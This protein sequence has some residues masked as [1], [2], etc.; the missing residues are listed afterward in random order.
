MSDHNTNEDRDFCGENFQVGKMASQNKC[1][2]AQ[3]TS[4]QHQIH[5]NF[6]A[7]PAF[8]PTVK[9]TPETAKKTAHVFATPVTKA[10]NVAMKQATINQGNKYSSHSSFEVGA[11]ERDS[12]S[13]VIDFLRSTDMGYEF[14]GNKQALKTNSNIEVDLLRENLTRRGYT[15]EQINAAILILQRKANDSGKTLYERNKDVYFLLRYGVGV[16][17]SQGVHEVKV[18]L[19]DWE[20]IEANHFAFAEEVSIAG[21]SPSSKNKRPDIVIYINGIAVSVLELKRSSVTV[22]EGIRQ[23]LDNQKPMFIESFFSTVQFVMAGNQTEGIRYGTIG[24]KAKYYME[25]QE[26]PRNA[27]EASNKLLMHLSQLCNKERLFE[28]I[29]DF[30]LFDSGLKKLCRQ[31]QYFAVKAAQ[32]HIKDQIKGYDQHGQIIW[33]DPSRP[34]G[35]IWHTQGAG[36][37]LIMVLLWRWIAEFDPKAKLLIITDRKELDDQI[38][39]VFA[40]VKEGEAANIYRATSGTDLVD[41]IKSTEV[42]YKATCSLIHKFGTK[43]TDD[44][45]PGAAKAYIE[46][47]KAKLGG[48]MESQNLYVYVDECHRT[49]S[50]ELHRAMKAVLPGAMFIGFTGTPLL[51][52]ERQSV[53]VFGNYIHKYLFPEAVRDGVVLDL[54]YE[55]RDIEQ[56]LS[57]PAKVDAWFDQQ[58]KRLSPYGK[59][60]VM[61]KWGTKQALLS[62]KSRIGKIAADI[63]VDFIVKP[64]LMDGS[65]GNA[66]LVAGS[67][68]EACQYFKEFDSTAL[69]GKVAIVT[70]YT[71][72]TSAVTGSA[73][74]DGDSENEFKFDVYVEMISDFMK[75]TKGEAPSRTE[76]FEKKVK[77]MFVDMPEQMRLLIVVDK[78]LTGFDAPS[79]TYL[80]IDKPMD[81]HGLFQAIC[82]TNRPDPNDETKDYGYIVDYRNLFGKIE[83]ALRDYAAGPFDGYEDDDVAGLL[84][85]FATDAAQK[86][87]DLRNEIQTLCAGVKGH[88]TNDYVAHYM[89]TASDNAVALKNKEQK[90]LKFY[91]LSDAYFRAVATIGSDLETKFDANV[92]AMIRKEADFFNNA[93]KEVKLACGDYVDMQTIE[94]GMRRLID[95]YVQ[96][97]ESTTVAGFEDLSLI[98]L[99]LNHG[100]DIDRAPDEVKTIIGNGKASVIEC[101]VRSLIVKSQTLNPTMFTQMSDLLT[102]IL[103]DLKNNANDY[104]TF[105]KKIKELAKQIKEPNLREGFPQ[106]INTRGRQDLYALLENHEQNAIDMDKAILDNREDDWR[107]LKMRRRS[108]SKA[109]ATVATQIIAAKIGNHTDSEAMVQQLTTDVMLLAENNFVDYP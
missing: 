7:K 51:K 100:D 13:L 83:G 99:V 46:E 29:H 55:A 12:Q 5:P 26:D 42:K 35:I 20:H 103:A 63:E 62:S 66:I 75:C 1:S 108:I 37:S 109:V 72:S 59:N 21:S 65:R 106:T 30:V 54:R 53:E 57:S 3:T 43:E 101:N 44:E 9:T 17:T 60:L 10:L 14:L 18:K 71:P 19:I 68:G 49:Q 86:I 47:V 74:G 87:S 39:K 23:N 27:L 82:R 64:R 98:D 58:T 94:P 69:K 56:S 90:R 34:G 16:K 38:V 105:L 41:A 91:K 8:V 85:D 4:A 76:E 79:A 73:T 70:S 97:G 6:N 36:K 2:S 32:K 80:Y 104:Q 77:S 11:L 92:A 24:T 48:A 102:K 78:L 84:K 88:E 89:P 50:G 61:K 52:T 40:G 67:I 33:A 107:T 28:F 93:S 81:N 22:G 25:W 95:L 15:Q 45:K 96:S 31:N